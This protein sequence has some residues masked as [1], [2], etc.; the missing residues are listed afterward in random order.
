MPT[1]LSTSK[2][3]TASSIAASISGVSS[4]PNAGSISIRRRRTVCRSLASRR[5]SS[6]RISLTLMAEVS[7]I[8]PMRQRSTIQP[9]TTQLRG[10]LSLARARYAV[11]IRRVRRFFSD[12][13][14]PTSDFR[15]PTSDFR[16]KAAFTQLSPHRN[17]STN[18]TNLERSLRNA[19]ISNLNGS[20]PASR[21]HDSLAAE[22]SPRRRRCHQGPTVQG[23]PP[24]KA[25][26]H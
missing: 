16:P 15:L 1:P 7:A 4:T 18:R 21:Y 6:S 11:V 14:L 2:A 24:R 13:R 3:R 22:R 26:P 5:G 19:S 25:L 9:R 10:F 12:F 17:A 20:R 8:V 23:T